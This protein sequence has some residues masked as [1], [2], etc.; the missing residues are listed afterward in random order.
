MIKEPAKIRAKIGADDEMSITNLQIHKYG[1]CADQRTSAEAVAV[2]LSA[3]KEDAKP[4]TIFMVLEVNF[5]HFWENGAPE[6][7]LK[8]RQANFFSPIFFCFRWIVI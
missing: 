5:D 6:N 2:S 8:N 1:T 7:S 4:P 3:P